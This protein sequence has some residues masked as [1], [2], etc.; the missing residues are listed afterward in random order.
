MFTFVRFV[1]HLFAFV[2]AAR[3]ESPAE[4]PRPEAGREGGA[5]AR[6]GPP[7]R[8]QPPVRIINMTFTH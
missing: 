4:G 2:T 5:E 8:S 6:P 3:P 1:H 7:E